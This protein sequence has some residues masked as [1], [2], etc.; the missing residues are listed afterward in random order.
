MNKKELSLIIILA[1]LTLPAIAGAQTLVSMA[2]SVAGV[3]WLVA[4]WIVV[5]MWVVTGLLYL[6]CLGDP[7]K[8]KSAN[9]SLFAAIAGTVL[10]IL[11]R[12]AM[13]FV[14]N[15]FGL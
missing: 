2:S 15:S 5:I 7:G 1:S 12:I 9:I 10:V 3:V 6:T 8:L 4:T 14:A 13:A 11:A